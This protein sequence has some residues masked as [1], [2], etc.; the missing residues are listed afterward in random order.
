MVDYMGLIRSET[1]LQAGLDHLRRLKEKV[2]NTML[3]RD[4][5]ELT[6]CLEVLNLYDLGELAFT[7]ALEKKESRGGFRRLDYPYSDPLLN[8]KTLVGKMVNGKPVV[9]WK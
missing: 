1:M 7:A 8:G 4:R 9:E 6:R 2:R 5:W 3:A